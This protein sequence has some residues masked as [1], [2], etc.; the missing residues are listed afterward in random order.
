MIKDYVY[1]EKNQLTLD[2]Y[3]PNKIE[4][5]I[6]L[7]H[8]GGWFRGDKSKETALAE[9][10]T[11]DGFLVVAPNYRLAPDHLFP[12]AMDDLLCLILCW[13]IFC[14]HLVTIR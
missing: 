14:C 3:E 10:L 4:A 1:D 13:Y 7:I 5:A 6:I 11:T 12:A 2:I 9:R 8:G